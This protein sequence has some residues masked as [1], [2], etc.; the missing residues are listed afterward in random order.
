[1]S[2]NP[3]KKYRESPLWK[4][5]ENAVADL[6]KNRDLTETTSREL[7]VGYITK[8]IVDADEVVPNIRVL[9]LVRDLRHTSKELETAVTPKRRQAV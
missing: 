1:M 7:I 6:V 4:T 8:Q 5:V 3:Y 2:T 9:N